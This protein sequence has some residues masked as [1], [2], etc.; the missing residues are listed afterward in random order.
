MSLA[1]SAG[2]TKAAGSVFG[3]L[4]PHPPDESTGV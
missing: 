1:Y 4:A 2:E 3:E